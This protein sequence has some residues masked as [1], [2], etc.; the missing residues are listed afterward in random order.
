MCLAVI[1]VADWRT[2]RDSD[3]GDVGNML[4]HHWSW[5]LFVWRIQGQFHIETRGRAYHTQKMSRVSCLRGYK[6]VTERLYLDLYYRLFTG[7]EWFDIGANW[8]D[9]LRLTYISRI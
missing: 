6:N 4:H 2:H 7:G 1:G 3:S 9:L 8:L 5:S